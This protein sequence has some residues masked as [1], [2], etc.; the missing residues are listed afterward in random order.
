[1]WTDTQLES[2]EKTRTY[3]QRSEPS[4]VNA[5]FYREELIPDD[6]FLQIASNA[7]SRLKPLSISAP[8]KYL[9]EMIAPYLTPRRFSKACTQVFACQMRSF[10]RYLRILRGT[11]A[12]NAN[13]SS[14]E[15][16]WRNM[17]NPTSIRLC[18]IPSGMIGT[19]QFPDFV[20][21]APR[22]RTIDLEL[23]TPVFAD[24]RG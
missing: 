19:T 20:E 12:P 6:P 15:L 5:V 17:A 10:L 7:I 16:P 3:L 11:S 14:Q 8:Q 2:V 22:L 24:G 9:F 18:V 23:A 13:F 21:S 1:L 4:P